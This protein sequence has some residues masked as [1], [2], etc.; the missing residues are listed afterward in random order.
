MARIYLVGDF[1]T[2]G[3][4]ARKRAAAV[5]AGGTVLP[6]NPNLSNKT[7]AVAVDASRQPGVRRRQLHDRGSGAPQLPRGG[8]R[9]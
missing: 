5:N 1:T 3:G 4:Q 7:Y 9:R 6:F 8:R 2:I